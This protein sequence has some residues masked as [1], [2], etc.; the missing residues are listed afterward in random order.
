MKEQT[1]EE[2]RLGGEPKWES[3]SALIIIFHLINVKEKE[4]FQNVRIGWKPTKPVAPVDHSSFD[5]AIGES[6]CV[7]SHRMGT[8]FFCLFDVCHSF[9]PTT[10]TWSGCVLRCRPNGAGSL[11]GCPFSR[12]LRSVFC[13]FFVFFCWYF[14]YSFFPPSSAGSARSF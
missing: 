12:P 2:R 10:T 3:E 6:C 1:K 5:D 4:I 9:I 13:F 14:F 7:D 11:S 8:H